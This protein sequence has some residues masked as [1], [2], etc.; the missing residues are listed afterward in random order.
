MGKEREFRYAY[1]K[2]T[3]TWYRVDEWEW[4]DK[5]NEQLVSK[6]KTEVDREDVPDKWIDGVK[7]R[8]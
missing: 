5:E 4:H 2:L 7:E 6:S 1:S 3:D 8:E